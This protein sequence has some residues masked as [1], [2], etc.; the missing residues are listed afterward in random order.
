V[1]VAL[2]GAKGSGKTT[3]GAEVLAPIFGSHGVVVVSSHQLA[4]KFSGHLADA[5][6]V[7][8]DEA[9]WA[10][11]R[12]ADSTLKQLITDKRRLAESKGKDA[13]SV[14]NRVGLLMAANAG[15]SVPTTVEDRRF[16]V[17]KVSGHRFVPQDA[18]A[19]HPNR[20]Y[21][22]ALYAE[23]E[24]GGRAAML[25]DLLRLEIGDWHPRTNVPKTEAQGEQALEGLRDYD[26]FYFEALRSGNAMEIGF[27]QRSRT[28][29]FSAG[30]GAEGAEDEW[31]TELKV[32]AAAVLDACVSWAAQKKR[33]FKASKKGLLEA[34]KPYGIRKGKNEKG[35]RCWTFPAL[36]DAR[37]LFAKRVGHDPFDETDSDE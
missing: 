22:D 16:F 19:D 29:D 36:P 3:L 18:P 25:H 7:F 21:W 9:V 6:F 24:G 17:L 35:A 5:L 10:G 20:L 31:A 26:Q 28:D 27:L 4:G 34:L 37:R 23:L 13:V 11:D 2:L 32:P 1:T 12:E 8:A 30:D 33:F 15:W 14:R